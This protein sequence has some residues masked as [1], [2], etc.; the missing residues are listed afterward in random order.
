MR[1]P[2]HHFPFASRPRHQETPKNG[3][4]FSFPNRY[5]CFFF[6]II[7]TFEGKGIDLLSLLLENFCFEM[8]CHR[9]PHKLCNGDRDVYSQFR[10]TRDTFSGAAFYLFLTVVKR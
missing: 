10:G 4:L 2:V 5:N 7:V 6:Q 9:C 8:V 3:H 1:Q